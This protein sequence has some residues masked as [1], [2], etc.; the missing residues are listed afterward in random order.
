[1]SSTPL[2]R[3]VSKVSRAEGATIAAATAPQVTGPVARR[4]EVEVGDSD[5][6]GPSDAYFFIDGYYY[7]KVCFHENGRPKTVMKKSGRG[8]S[9]LEGRYKARTDVASRIAH[10]KSHTAQKSSP[11]QAIGFDKLFGQGPPN[12]AWAWAVVDGCHSFSSFQKE[13][14]INAIR[15]ACPASTTI[16]I[17]ST[18]ELRAAVTALA[19]HLRGRGL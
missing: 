12:E 17:P 5:D 7:C 4:L 13:S 11:H 3:S 9:G 15:G 6:E 2:D 18:S 19:A 8:G 1:M 10:A 16:K 14:L